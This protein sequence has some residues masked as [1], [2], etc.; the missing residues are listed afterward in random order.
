MSRTLIQNTQPCHVHWYKTHNHV[1]YADTKHTTMSRTLIQNTQPCHVHWYKTHSN[2]TYT[3][4][5]HTTMS[6]TLIQNT[7]PCHVHWYKIEPREYESDDRDAIVKLHRWSV[8]C[9]CRPMWY[10]GLRW[11]AVWLAGQNL[12]VIQGVSVFCSLGSVFIGY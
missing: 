7:Q 8:H 3:D 1:T 9:L 10:F 11:Y 4:T 12:V 5:K 6:R 2:V